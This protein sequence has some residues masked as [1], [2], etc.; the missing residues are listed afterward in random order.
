MSQGAV[1][2]FDFGQML[3]VQNIGTGMCMYLAGGAKKSINV[4]ALDLNILP[5][6]FWTTKIA[7]TREKNT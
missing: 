1:V 6:L 3:A 5:S 2:N 4:F 7:S